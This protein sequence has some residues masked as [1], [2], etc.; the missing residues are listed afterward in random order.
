[1]STE[2]TRKKSGPAKVVKAVAFALVVAAVTKEMQKEPQ[3]RTWNG[4]VAGFVPYEFRLPTVER[5]KSRV[6]D[7]EGEHI[8]SPRIF[9]VGWTVNVGRVVAVTK[10]VLAG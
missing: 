1:M 3:D 5:I 2:T 6:W 8:L 7:P 9:G 10:N 4:T